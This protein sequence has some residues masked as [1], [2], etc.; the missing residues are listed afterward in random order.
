VKRIVSKC[1][2][3]GNRK[4][5][6]FVALVLTSTTGFAQDFFRD[7]GTSRSSG[8][9]GPVIPSEYNLNAGSPSAMTRVKPGTEDIEEDSRYNIAIGPV[10]ISIAAGVGV[11][12]ND[13]IALSEDNRQSD[14]IIRPVLNADVMWLIGPDANLRF[15]LGASWSKY[16]EHSEFDSGGLILSPNTAIALTFQVGNVDITIRDRF[17]YQ[18]E[19]YDIAPL[20]NVA[21]YRR[22]ENQAGIQFDWP[23]N[24]KLTL[25]AGYDRY[26][27]WSKDE[28][29]ES[30]DRTLDTIFIRPG[31]QLTPAIKVGIWGS[32]SFIDFNSEDRAD[33][34]ATMIGPFIDW[35]ISDYLTLYLEAG[36]QGIEFDGTSRFDNDFFAQV[37]PEFF[38]DL[39]PEERDLFTD[40]S[41]ASS[42]YVKFELNH[43]PNENFEHGISF[44]KTAEIG[45]GSNFYDL[46]HIE[47]GASYKGIRDMELGGLV[48]YEFYETSGN[49]SEKADRIGLELSARYHLT[50]SIALGLDYRFLIKDSDLE[51]ADYYQNLVFLSLYYRF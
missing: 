40:S 22:Y 27:L 45:F 24:E 21:R 25:T 15:N 36:Y 50:E 20:S 10:R 35:T 18:E 3:S 30:E 9:I 1:T 29:F 31:Y 6:P 14:F 26:S 17:S 46:Y 28:T 23:V 33:S 16:L 11:E 7:I 47:Y 32:Y 42:F 43:T 19:P 5:A 4:W 38:E 12:W 2:E 8:G 44:T 51:G 41:S 34:G 13:N 49:F 37:N 48:F 39:T